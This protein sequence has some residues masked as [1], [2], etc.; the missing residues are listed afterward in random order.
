MKIS[1]RGKVV[2]AARADTGKNPKQ[3]RVLTISPD[4]VQEDV[5][6]GHV[7]RELE[8][9]GT[10]GLRF[11]D[12]CVCHAGHTR[13]QENDLVGYWVEKRL[14][15]SRLTMS[16]RTSKQQLRDNWNFD[17]WINVENRGN[18]WLTLET[19]LLPHLKIVLRRA[20]CDTRGG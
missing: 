20:H 17:A 7:Q 6:S 18:N 12:A 2:P 11:V 9:E 15:I 8:G 13:R 16:L 4:S 3:A 5:S 14:Q 1:K 10:Y 19:A